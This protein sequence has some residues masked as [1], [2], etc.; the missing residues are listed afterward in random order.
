MKYEKLKRQ[1]LVE[2]SIMGAVLLVMGAIIYLISSVLE[3][4]EGSNQALQKQVDAVDLEMNTLKGRFMN[5]QKNIDIYQEVLKKKAEG[6]LAINRQ[7]V[8]EKFNQYKTQ[9]S[10]SSLRMTVSPA[11]EVKDAIFKRKNS[12]VNFSDVA[13]NFE[14]TSDENIYV[15]LDSLREELPGISKIIRVNM[16]LQHPFNDEVFQNISKKGV[17]PLVKT[18]IRFIWF[19]INS[20]EPPPNPAAKPETKPDANAPKN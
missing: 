7:M 5:I 15:L 13:V 3:D 19:G 20:T 2:A 8:L 17:Y 1:V 6:R 9:Y 11:Q 16:V 4:Y 10:L 12:D 18:D 14:V